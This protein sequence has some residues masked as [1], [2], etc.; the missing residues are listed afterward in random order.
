MENFFSSSANRT[1]A[2]VVL[3]ALI[4]ALGSYTYFTIQ[5]AKYL[6]TG[7][8]TVSV[9]GEGEV[10]AVPDIARF[11]F[12]IIEKAPEVEVARENAAKK[13]NEIIEALKAEG[14]DEKD[15]K[16]DYYNIYPVYRYEERYCTMGWCPGEQVEDGFEVNQTIS[17]KVRE[18]S[19]VGKFVTLVSDRG[20]TSLSGI[21]FTIDDTSALKA[22]AREAAIADA[23]V[24]ADQLADNLGVRLG[25]MVGYYE[26]EGYAAPY[27]G[28]YGM[29]G[30]MMVKEASIV[31]DIPAGEN[32]LTSRVTLTFQIR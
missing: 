16:T 29:G 15:I 28:G 5:S 26:D 24:K 1:L 19:E 7:P 13:S 9:T 8:T 12:S 31:P 30:D 6:Y 3:G 4:V 21:E 18:Q 14:V 17:V 11:N 25:K 27:Y 20:V 2:G 32:T 23:K 22:E 10:V